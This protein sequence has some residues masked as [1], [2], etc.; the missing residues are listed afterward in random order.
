[1]PTKI[2]DAKP[3]GDWRV[4]TG[5]VDFDT[6]RLQQ[7]DVLIGCNP[8][9][10]DGRTIAVDGLTFER[11][12]MFGVTPNP[13]WTITDCFHYGK[14]VADLP[15]PPTDHE[16]EAQRIDSLTAELAE[17]AVR[18]PVLVQDSMK[19]QPALVDVSKEVAKVSDEPIIKEGA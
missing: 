11:C 13:T 3:I 17:I 14:T 4:W 7:G 12:N 15:V 9:H 6:V 8:S 5:I 1:M 10:M 16:V 19:L 18:K 2:D